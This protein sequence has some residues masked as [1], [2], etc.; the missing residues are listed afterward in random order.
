[1]AAPVVD[2]EAIPAPPKR[3]PPA[4]FPQLTPIPETPPPARWPR[5]D[6]RKPAGESGLRGLCGPPGLSPAIA[7]RATLAR[8]ESFKLSRAA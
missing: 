3:R 6:S 5:P 1:V 7:R 8:W 2:G 4:A